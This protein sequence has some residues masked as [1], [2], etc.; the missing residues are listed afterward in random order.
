MHE[1]IGGTMKVLRSAAIV[2]QGR[3]ALPSAMT[4]RVRVVPVGELPGFLLVLSV[5]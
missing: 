2:V 3:H 1:T 5:A 4:A